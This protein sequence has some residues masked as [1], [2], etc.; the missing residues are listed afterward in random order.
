MTND[1]YIG[2]WLTFD[3]FSWYGRPDEVTPTHWTLQYTTSRDADI[4]T[5]SNAAYID[6]KMAPYI[7]SGDVIPQRINHWAVGWL[8]GYAIKVYADDD[9]TITT[10]AWDTFLDIKARQDD[11]PV[12]DEEDFSEREENSKHYNVKE[13]LSMI[14]RDLSTDDIAWSVLS[15]FEQSDDYQHEMES[16]DSWP[17]DEALKAAIAALIEYDY[18]I[19]P[20]QMEV[21]ACCC[22]DPWCNANDEVKE[23]MK[24]SEWAWFDV[25]VK[26]TIDGLEYTDA[27][28]SCSYL[29]KEDWESSDY[30]KDMKQAVLNQFLGA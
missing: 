11:Y 3:S 14:N 26:G 9:C 28:G 6:K 1:K 16:Y 29:S 24:Y 18:E 13:A 15:W 17:S 27:L 5:E 22:D 4:L 12:L 23:R 19:R 8:E 7:E 21:E 20:S 2:N 25:V 10:E 30:Y